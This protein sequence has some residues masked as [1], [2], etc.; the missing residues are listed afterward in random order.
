MLLEIVLPL[1]GLSAD[2][3][4]EGYVVLVAALVD[5]EVVGLC[6]AS[7]AIL[8]NELDGALGSHLLP[9]AELPAVPLC[10]H[11][12]YREHP[13][14]FP[15]S[16]LLRLYERVC[17]SSLRSLSPRGPLWLTLSLSLSRTCKSAFFLT[18]PTTRVSCI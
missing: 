16:G 8:A 7:L 9:A 4:G 15:L 10:L 2:L 12:H 6:E 1:K 11:W 3:A 13:Y 5:H 14:K 17:A 18:P